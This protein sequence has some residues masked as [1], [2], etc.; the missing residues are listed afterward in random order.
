LLVKASSSNNQ[1]RGGGFN[2][3]RGGTNSTRG[4]ANNT[5]GVANT[6]RGRGRGQDRGRGVSR[7]QR[8]EQQSLLG[9]KEQNGVY[10][11]I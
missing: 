6:Q 1:S 8:G 10:E 7:G 4:V 5:R 9:L 2:N 3:T 11:E